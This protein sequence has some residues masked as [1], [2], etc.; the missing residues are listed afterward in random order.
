MGKWRKPC[1]DAIKLNIDGSTSD[2][3]F[4]RGGIFCNSFGHIILAYSKFYDMGTNNT[5]ESRALFDGIN[6]VIQQ[7]YSKIEV[8]CDSKVIIDCHVEYQS[9]SLILL[10]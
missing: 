7:G 10:L 3:M 6:F 9:F 4:T 5:A 8:E 1:E 2:G